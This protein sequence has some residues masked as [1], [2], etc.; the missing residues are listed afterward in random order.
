MIRDQVE[1]GEE[2]FGALVCAQWGE[3]HLYALFSRFSISWR[4]VRVNA[5]F[6]LGVISGNGRVVP[7]G[8]EYSLEKYTICPYL[9]KWVIACLILKG[10]F[11]GDKTAMSFGSRFSI[12]YL[13]LLPPFPNLNWVALV[14][15]IF[16][17]VEYDYH[18]CFWESFIPDIWSVF[19]WS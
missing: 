11:K 15:V 8:C 17:A 13:I 9:W 4:F 12:F 19:G 6:F 10:S 3:K 7:L 1:W 14:V 5:T 2:H 16:Q 18:L